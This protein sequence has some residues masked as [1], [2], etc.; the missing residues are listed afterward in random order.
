MREA[1]SDIYVPHSPGPSLFFFSTRGKLH[2]S[3]PLLHIWTSGD[4][5]SVSLL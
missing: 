1:L 4:D 3:D 5:R 2:A